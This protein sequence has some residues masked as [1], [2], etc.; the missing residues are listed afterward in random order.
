MKEKTANKIDE[1][2]LAYRYQ[3]TIL[4]EIIE[5]REEK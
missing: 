2:I 1:K 5:E 4:Q 3:I